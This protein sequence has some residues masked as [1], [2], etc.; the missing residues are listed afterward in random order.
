MAK[1]L[2]FFFIVIYSLNVTNSTL[3]KPFAFTIMTRVE[4]FYCCLKI[5]SSCESQS[6]TSPLGGCQKKKKIM[7]MSPVSEFFTSLSL[8]FCFF[9]SFYC[10]TYIWRDKDEE[11]LRVYKKGLQGHMLPSG[12]ES[13]TCL[14]KHTNFL[15]VRLDSLG[16]GVWIIKLSPHTIT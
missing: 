6:I 9:V 15:W 5:G 8:F 10:C 12:P 2:S 11:T 3:P 4:K 16:S 7:S 1:R 14:V 13:E